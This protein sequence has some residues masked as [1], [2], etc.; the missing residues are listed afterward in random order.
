[1]T[2][3]TNAPILR[4]EDTKDPKDPKIQNIF[5][6]R[7]ENYRYSR[8]EMSDNGLEFHRR[9]TLRRPLLYTNGILFV[10]SGILNR[11]SKIPYANGQ[12]MDLV[13]KIQVASCNER[14]LQRY[15]LLLNV[16]KL[17]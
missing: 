14:I 4:R 9:T 17:V 13:P 12:H 11:V 15:W 16:E 2:R 3:A 6:P 1:M 5:C 8:Y 10:R 7:L